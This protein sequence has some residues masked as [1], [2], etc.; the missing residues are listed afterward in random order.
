MK[1][2]NGLIWPR[3]CGGAGGP[4]DILCSREP[5]LRPQAA[6]SRPVAS[7]SQRPYSASHG[8]DTRLQE[9]LPCES[10]SSSGPTPLTATPGS[11][12]PLSS[13]AC[14]AEGGKSPAC[15]S[16][17]G[18]RSPLLVPVLTFRLAF[19]FSWCGNAWH[20]DPRSMKYRARLRQPRAG[21]ARSRCCNSEGLWSH[22]CGSYP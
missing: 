17:R 20:A 18:L 22:R 14:G 9:R 13:R 4:G 11:P 6:S 1:P 12:Q 15:L 21:H 3:Q 7:G 8:A 19:S 10:Q 16:P 2:Q 5:V